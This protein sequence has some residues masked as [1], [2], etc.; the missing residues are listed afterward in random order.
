MGCLLGLGAVLLE[1]CGRHGVL[2]ILGGRTQHEPGYS[3]A[4]TAVSVARHK[5]ATCV[6]SPSAADGLALAR[7]VSGAEHYPP[8]TYC[9]HPCKIKKDIRMAK[10]FRRE[11][12]V[13]GS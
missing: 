12:Q 6:R 10:T 3:F 11:G 13:A 5:L 7:H 9:T 4:A 2:W 8:Q 1:C